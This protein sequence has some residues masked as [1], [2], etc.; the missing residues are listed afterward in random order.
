[1]KLKY[2]CGPSE[3][4]DGWM[5]MIIDME[6]EDG[7]SPV[8]LTVGVEDTEYQIREWCLGSI[9]SMKRGGEELPDRLGRLNE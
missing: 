9:E 8:V 7:G 6:P 3:K 5:G 1:M 2:K 4:A